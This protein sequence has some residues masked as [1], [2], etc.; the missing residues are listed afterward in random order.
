M[1]KLHR[2]SKDK[3]KITR[4]LLFNSKTAT[5]MSKIDRKTMGDQYGSGPLGMHRS[6]GASL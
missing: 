6:T 3:V 4:N 5:K 2:E 1:A